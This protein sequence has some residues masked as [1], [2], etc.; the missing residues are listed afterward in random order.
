M[1][2]PEIKV[3][4]DPNMIEDYVNR[5][6]EDVEIQ[7][8]IYKKLL[9]QIEDPQWAKAIEVEHETQRICMEM[10]DNG[11]SFDYQG[12]LD[13]KNVIEGEME[14]IEG[15]MRDSIPLTL[16]QD[17]PVTLKRNKD[18]QPSKKTTEAIGRSSFR[19][20]AVWERFHYEEFNP[21][22]S[23]Q[24]IEL[25]NKSGWKPIEKTKGHL[26]CERDLKNAIRF[27]EKESK[28]KNLKE[29]MERY[30][31][32]G[33]K[34]NEEN[35]STLPVGSPDGVRLL[36]TWLTLEGRRSDL[37]EWCAAYNSHSGRIH[38]KF[39]GLGAW[40][41]RKAHSSPNQGNI[42]SE[43]HL[44]Q[45][46]NPSE[47]SPVEDIKLRFNGVLRGLWR[48]EPGAF[49]VGADAEGIQLRILAHLI[50]DPDYRKTIEKG[51][52]KNKTDI[53]NVNMRSLAPHCKSRD[54]AKTFIYA[55]VLNAQAA[56]VSGI[57]GCSFIEAREAMRMFLEA[58]PALKEY[59]HHTIPQ[60]AKKRYFEGLDGRLVVV[61]SEHKVLA[62]EL[63]NGE[64][65]VMKHATILW[66][67]WADEDGLRYKL[68]DDVHDEWQSEV[69][70]RE[71]GH[72]LGQ[73][74]CDALIKTGQELGVRCALAGD[75]DIGINWR[76]T[77]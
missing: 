28:I 66:R 76:E 8:R 24:R 45:C 13:L 17:K 70:D 22:S 1:Y 44:D 35:L 77:H 73:L 26:Q 60:I 62:G 42:F 20:E 10:H 11:F 51:D 38:G 25:L 65:V 48:A 46:R 64:S 33:W 43:F 15:K 58:N 2:K 63:Q 39:K 16:H 57:L 68:V 36:A 3:Y 4:D 32:Y 55:W 18:G 72:R 54:D 5:C 59:K 56:R 50:N 9:R 12:A 37:E 34:V 74:K 52:K 30:K 6:E 75:Y 40:S 71:V 61:P 14:E 53:H 41:H 23:K 47:P 21:G 49:L 27:R 67:K 69:Y 7:Y 31:I 19:S 29:R